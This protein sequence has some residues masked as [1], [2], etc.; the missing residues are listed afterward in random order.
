[1]PNLAYRK[2]ISLLVIWFFLFTSNGYSTPTLYKSNNTLRPPIGGLPT[3]GGNVLEEEGEVILKNDSHEVK[4]LS[5]QGYTVYHL[6]DLRSGSSFEIVPE[7]GAG[8]ISFKVGG[9]EFLLPSDDLN[10]SLRGI[11]FMSP[12]NRVR[13]EKITIHGQEFDLSEIDEIS[14]DGKG[15]SI[16]GPLRGMAWELDGID[17]DEQGITVECSIDLSGTR[18]GKIFGQ[19]KYTLIYTLKGNKLSK[20]VRIVNNDNKP[21]DVGCAWHDWINAEDVSGWQ[22]VLPASEYCVTEGLL[23]TGE[24]RP[25]QEIGL[26][27]GKAIGLAG[28]AGVFD[29]VLTGL[30]SDDG[31]VTSVLSH[32]EENIR[33]IFRQD[34]RYLKY[35]V[36]FIHE[37][38]RSICVEAQSC[39]TDAHNLKAQGIASDL[40]TIKQGKT[41]EV[42]SDIEIE[43]KKP[44]APLDLN[45]APA[46]DI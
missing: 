31:W 40:I 2:T 9:R 14:D 8:V 20:T 37:D 28:Q 26:E 10:K 29:H 7:R 44:N 46:Q 3:R 13:G 24:V 6:T 42:S 21:I 18:L 19:A 17:S 22:A 43:I 5:R 12:P 23:P 1:M 34:G 16:H 33:V 25:V 4:K 35:I 30:E 39:F 11:P 15:N 32:R 36:F 45:Q 41:I 27:Q 38:G